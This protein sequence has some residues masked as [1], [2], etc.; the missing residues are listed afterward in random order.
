MAYRGIRHELA[1]P[2]GLLPLSEKLDTRPVRAAPSRRYGRARPAGSRSNLR[3]QEAHLIGAK[4]RE[5]KLKPKRV[6]WTA[7]F[8]IPSFKFQVRQR[9]LDLK[10]ET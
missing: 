3:N 6:C 4:R 7:K 5:A 9:Q 10:L 8:Q 1:E 2:R